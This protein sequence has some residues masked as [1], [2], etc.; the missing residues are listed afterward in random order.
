MPQVLHRAD[1][2]FRCDP[3]AQGGDSGNLVG[4]HNDT[5]QPNR[6]LYLTGQNSSCTIAPVRVF[7]IPAEPITMLLANVTNRTLVI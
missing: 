3:A 1:N 2:Y 6:L 4:L 7:S 5:R